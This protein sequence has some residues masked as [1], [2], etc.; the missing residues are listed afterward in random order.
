MLRF[1]FNISYAVT[2]VIGALWLLLITEALL[3]NVA[4]LTAINLT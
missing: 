4:T 1:M 2:M 3:E